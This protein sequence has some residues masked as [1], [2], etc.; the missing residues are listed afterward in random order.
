MHREFKLLER[1]LL[2]SKGNIQ[3]T[4]NGTNTAD[5]VG[6]RERRAKL[7]CFV[8]HIDDTMKQI[9]IGFELQSEGKRAVGAR[10]ELSGGNSGASDDVGDLAGSLRPRSRVAV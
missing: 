2:R 4:K 7:H 1:Q 3:K 10:I 5:S 6:P 9:E 8:Q